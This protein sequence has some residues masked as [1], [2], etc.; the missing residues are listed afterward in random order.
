MA[1]L[2]T[3]I[4][5]AVA[6]L[7]SGGVL[8]YPTEAI[9]GLGCCPDNE[10]AVA[11]LVA[12]KGRDTLKGLILVAANWAQCNALIAP[13]PEDK[14]K[15]ALASWPGPYTWIFPASDNTPDWLTSSDRKIA[16]RISDHPTVRALCEAFGGPIVSTSANISN[17][18]PCKT[19]EAVL[20]TFQ[21]FPITVLSGN[22][23][24]QSKPSKI[25]DVL[26]GQILRD[27]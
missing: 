27:A 6:V 3:E 25:M 16:L 12:I 5:D 19:Q 21:S 23:G 17:Q 11:C 18:P 8:A 1:S 7:K 4:A 9:Y 10:E 20:K 13:L 22:V 14:L 15:P 24:R 2:I 26:T